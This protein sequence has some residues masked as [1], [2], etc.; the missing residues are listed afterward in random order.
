MAGNINILLSSMK[1]NDFGPDMRYM[2]NAIKASITFLMQH[3]INGNFAYKAGVTDTK[4]V[5]FCHGA[6]GIV[7]ALAKFAEMFPEIGISM[8]LK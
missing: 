6:P 3:L 2:L 1:L 5:H 7:T 4:L 8:G